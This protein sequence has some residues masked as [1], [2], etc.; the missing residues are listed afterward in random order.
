MIELI[1]RNRVTHLIAV[2]SVLDLI[3]RD[4]RDLTTW[5]E[6]SVQVVVTG[7]EVCPPSLINRWLETVPGLRVLYGYGP[8]ECNSLCLT[9][10][11]VSPKQTGSHL[12]RS[13]CLSAA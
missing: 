11:I 5:A 12:I 2:S 10:E 8:T 4:V 7:G 1:L 13:A 9:S 6:S 3:S